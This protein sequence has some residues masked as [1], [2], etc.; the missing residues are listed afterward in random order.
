V[1]ALRVDRVF[2][3]GDVLGHLAVSMSSFV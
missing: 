3:V 2:E 1:V